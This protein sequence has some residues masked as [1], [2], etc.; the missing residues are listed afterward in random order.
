MYLY[1]AFYKYIFNLFLYRDNLFSENILKIRPSRIGHWT[2]IIIITH[3]WILARPVTLVFHKRSSYNHL[4]HNSVIV[5]LPPIP[6]ASKFGALTWIQYLSG[7]TQRTLHMH[8]FPIYPWKLFYLG[9]I[10]RE[11]KQL[12]Q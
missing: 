4:C 8:F 10:F 7:N 3:P 5:V 1:I 2:L 9:V 6:A 12:H 11:A